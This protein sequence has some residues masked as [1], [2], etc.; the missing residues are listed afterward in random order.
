MNPILWRLVILSAIALGGFVGGVAASRAHYRPIIADM[1]EK[2]AVDR[3]KAAEAVAKAVTDNDAL[4]TKLGV[5]HA[6]NQKAV[7]DL[8]RG[9][10]GTR[11]QL[12]ACMPSAASSSSNAATGS[13]SSVAGTQSL[14]DNTQ[15]EFDRF[16]ERLGEEA[17]YADTVIESCRVLKL[18][19][20]AQ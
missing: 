6:N 4:K 20:L 19:S 18:W 1:K 5:D 8:F 15:A 17:R 10:A 3:Q 9:L 7:D 11:V 2:A 13:A 12:P 16:T 14:P